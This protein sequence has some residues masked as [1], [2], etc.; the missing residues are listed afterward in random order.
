MALIYHNNKIN[1][2]NSKSEL[3]QLLN[4]YKGILNS[5]MIDYL[6][7][8]IDLKESVIK[9]CI[10]EKD[11]EKLAEL[12]L[13][14]KVARYNIYARAIEIFNNSGIE[15]EYQGNEQGKEGLKVSASN[16]MHSIPL[17]DYNYREKTT[18]KKIPDGYK[19]MNIGYINLF[20]LIENAEKREAELNRVLEILKK[21]YDEKNPYI[22]MPGV[23]GG[24]HVVWQNNHDREVLKYENLLKELDSKNNL[25]EADL[26]EI[27]YTRIAHKLLLDD[28]GLTD[29]S[30]DEDAPRL[31]TEE[32]REN[33]QQKIKRLS[34]ITLYNN[35]K[36]I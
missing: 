2:I 12:E 16:G 29:A 23:N 9:N 27:E 11:R 13:Y 10:S 6:E 25:T 15:V 7:S 14:K 32:K 19:T 30:F 8:L 31:I 18:D 4:E 36:Y 35:I 26:K 28:Y 5:T 3:I 24:P 17:F 22:S 1:K 34:T 21:L 20:Q 33:E